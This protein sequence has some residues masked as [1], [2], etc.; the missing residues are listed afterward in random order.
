M[1]LRAVRGCLAGRLCKNADASEMRP[2]LVKSHL[3]PMS[4]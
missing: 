3:M 2:N 1:A 4:L